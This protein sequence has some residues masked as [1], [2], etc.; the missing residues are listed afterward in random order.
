VK[1]RIQRPPVQTAALL[2]AAGWYLFWLT[3]FRPA[4]AQRVDSAELPAA[5]RLSEWDR[6]LYRLQD[7]TLFALPS[8]DG[9]SG[10]FIKNRI[11]IRLSL[12]K[13]EHP[14]RYLERPRA[15][16]PAITERLLPAERRGSP[17][18]LPAPGAAAPAARPPRKGTL[19]F[20]SPELQSRAAAIGP[21]TLPVE[22]P[23][24]TVQVHLTV[25]PDG[26]VA[27]AFF[28]TPVTNTAL[29]PAVRSLRF[30]PD[31]KTSAGR[32]NILFAPE[33]PR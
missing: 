18:V 30:A 8:G 19:L 11:G 24:A 3:A 15:P 14:A 20:F 28:E 9:F 23:S 10:E 7:P 22:G 33:E 6:S 25:R 26:T 1:F 5:A 31:E 12:E 2:G 21:E 29:I 16:A 32:L 27:H 17:A 4:P 13:P